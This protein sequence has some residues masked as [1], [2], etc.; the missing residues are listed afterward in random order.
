MPLPLVITL[1]LSLDVCDLFLVLGEKNVE[2][3]SFQM[4]VKHLV[5]DFMILPYKSDSLMT[6]LTLVKVPGNLKL[7]QL[8]KAYPYF[9]LTHE[10]IETNKVVISMGRVV[11]PI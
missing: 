7:S 4:V 2:S 6:Y 1:T 8:M 9:S 5:M 10:T 3:Y 11:S